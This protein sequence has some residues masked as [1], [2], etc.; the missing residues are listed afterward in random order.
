MATTFTLTPKH[1]KYA[2]LAL[3]LVCF[4]AVSLPLSFWLTSACLLCAAV[5]HS[6]DRASAKKQTHRDNVETLL[7]DIADKESGSTP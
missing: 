7:G 2:S 1:A 3:A 4:C 5:W 6:L